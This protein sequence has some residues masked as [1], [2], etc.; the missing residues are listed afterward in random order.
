MKKKKNAKRK[1]LS[2]KKIGTEFELYSQT[3]A[4]ASVATKR[5]KKKQYYLANQTKIKNYQ[6]KKY[7]K[8]LDEKEA[9]WDAKWKEEQPKFVKD[10]KEEKEK[11]GRRK[12][13]SGMKFSKRNLETG[14]KQLKNF[15]LANETKVIIKNF[16]G[17]IDET[18]NNFN[19]KIDHAVNS[20]RDLD[21]VV[22]VDK[23]YDDLFNNKTSTIYNTWHDLKLSIDV[24]FIQTARKFGKKYPGCTTCICYKCQDAIGVKNIKKAHVN[25]GYSIPSNSRFEDHMNRKK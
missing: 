22:E 18:Y 24:E 5:E 10:W 20:S 14:L 11:K 23:C 7:K 17:K 9:Y 15:G 2:R 8:T 16:E 1:Q 13:D 21:C 4:Y 3:E 19:A 6:R 25:A 12:N